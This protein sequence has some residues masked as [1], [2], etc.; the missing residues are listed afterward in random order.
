MLQMRILTVWIL[1]VLINIERD[2]YTFRSTD[3]RGTVFMWVY[4]D[5]VNA[6]DRIFSIGKHDGSGTNQQITIGCGGD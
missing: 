1:M 2:E 3:D 4:P 6:D 5:V